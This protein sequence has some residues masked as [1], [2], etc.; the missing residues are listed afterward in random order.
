MSETSRR[1]GMHPLL[2]F[3]LCFLL[4]FII[5]AGSVV[6]VVV[7]ALNFKLD[8]IDANKDADG[9]YLFIN[10]NPED[11]G[12]GTV[13]DLIKKV[14]A[15][16]TGYSEMTVGEVEKLIPIMSSLTGKLE[17][18]LNN[19]MNLEEGELQ[20]V[21]LGALSEFVGSLAER[22]NVAKLIGT[23]TDNAILLYMSY[24]V[25][26]LYEKDGEWHAKYKDEGAENGEEATVY[27]C[28]LEMREDG[29]I[30][31]AF[32]EKDGETVYTPYLTLE[33]V[34]ERVSGVCEELTIGEI[35]P[36]DS[37]DRI[38][39]SIKNSTVNTISQDINNLCIQQIFA[40]EVYAPATA[41]E[42]ETYDE[43][44]VYLAVT[45]ESEM[46]DAVDFGYNKDIIYYTKD[47]DNHYLLAGN[48]GKIKADDYGDGT[49]LYTLGAGKIL[50]DASYLYYTMDE[51]EDIQMI[52][53]GKDNAGRA[54]APLDGEEI[55]TYGASSPLWKL[56]IYMD[57]EEKAFTFNNVGTMITN[58]SK[59]TQKTHMRDL[60]AAGILSFEGH[61][62]DLEM[63]I[64]F[65]NG[66]EVKLGDLTLSEVVSIAVAL[67]K[68]PVL[69]PIAQPEAQP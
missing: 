19:Y 1:R 28:T 24:G 10:A 27:D 60:H 47:D 56:L 53:A 48:N 18:E 17:N 33:N 23:T 39:G 49:D 37:D 21:K 3:F 52:N 13:L 62:D 34:K 2:A 46:H 38:L 16:S 67:F 30:D 32:Y 66:N 59:N 4:A 20:D 25:H 8:K 43:A 40:N 42:G 26:G 44:L 69:P 35:V 65:T 51:A 54:D 36:L 6:G 11:G 29:K 55:Y 5:V 15:M 58:V 61:E 68:S 50:Y 9:N 12:V 64:H 22:V 7:F 63:P 57:E 45:D 41:S 31:G 14:S